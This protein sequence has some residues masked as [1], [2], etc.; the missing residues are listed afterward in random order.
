MSSIIKETVSI[1][2]ICPINNENTEI[3]ATYRK[4]QPLGAERAYAIVLGIQCP[5]SNNCSIEQCPI[6]YSRVYW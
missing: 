1:T 5:L 4:Y 3:R 6:A 2:G